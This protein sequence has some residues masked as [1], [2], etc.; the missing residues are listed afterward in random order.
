MPDTRAEKVS[1][2]RE[3]RAAGLVFREIGEIM[4]AATST[5]DSW[6]NDPDL[7]KHRA[8]RYKY[9]G[10][11]IDC[12]NP[13]D[14]SD[15]PGRA[16]VRCDSCHHEYQHATAYWTPERVIEAI[17][18]FERREG[19]PPRATDFNP[20]HP[21]AQNGRRERFL[22]SRERGEKYPT[23][24]SVLGVF[25]TWNAAIRAAGFEPGICGHYGRPGEDMALCE[26]IRGEYEAGASTY[27]LGKQY[28][29]SDN[30]IAYRIH[31]AGGILRSPRAAQDLRRER[32]AA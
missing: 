31:K 14:G 19:C 27:M 18:E 8:R 24:S 23:V 16:A 20:A 1:R 11:C 30:A 17:Q 32:N 15:G 9:G 25:D 7:S 5:V 29:C 2:A 26:R 28:G 3:L 6:L 12:G 10:I 22:A 4:G 21:S 13:T